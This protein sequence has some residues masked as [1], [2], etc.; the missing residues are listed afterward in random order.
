MDFEQWQVVARAHVESL[1]APLSNGPVKSGR[2]PPPV[3]E[4]PPPLDLDQIATLRDLAAAA[5]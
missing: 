2:T 4:A 1:G 5:R 3:E